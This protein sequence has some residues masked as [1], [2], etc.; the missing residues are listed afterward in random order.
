[1]NDGP[2]RGR[3]NEIWVVR[4]GETE[5]S[6]T[7]RHTSVTDL[8]MTERGERD[9][10]ALRPALRDH[11][12]ALVA[13]SPSARAAR[14]AELAGFPDAIRDPDLAEWHYGD[15]EGRTTSEIRAAQPGWTVWYGAIPGGETVEDVERR[16]RSVL[17]RC[18]EAGGDALLFGHGHCLR[19]LTAVALGFSGR[20]GCRFAL[21]AGAIGVIGH[22]HEY[23]T[24]RR[25]NTRP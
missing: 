3:R 9:A 11:R 7:G 23:R 5:W 25:W 22:E 10:V 2:G 21:E 24:L 6:R 13:T 12:F 15:H 4:H 8:P 19:V 17:S 18:D 1:M 14:T 20:D 16:V